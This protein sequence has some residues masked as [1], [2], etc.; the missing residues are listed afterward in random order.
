MLN[1]GFS[2][3]ATENEDFSL[4]LL[5]PDTRAKRVSPSSWLLP[6]IYQEKGELC[7]V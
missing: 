4:C 2:F 1:Q 7:E 6:Y 3:E 5:V